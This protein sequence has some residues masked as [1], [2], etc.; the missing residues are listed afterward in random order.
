MSAAELSNRDVTGVPA[1]S[2]SSAGNSTGQKKRS[3]PGE[4]NEALPEATMEEAHIAVMGVTGSG[5]S[6]F[7]QLLTGQDVPI[8]HGLPIQ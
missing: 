2:Q 8:G 7:V 3:T 4:I 6:T 5:K 1:S